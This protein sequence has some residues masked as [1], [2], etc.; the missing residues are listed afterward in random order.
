MVHITYI[1]VVMFATCYMEIKR[2]LICYMKTWKALLYSHECRAVFKAITALGSIVSIRFYVFHFIF[3]NKVIF[4]KYY[5]GWKS[6][7]NHC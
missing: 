4:I 3:N 7:K 1:K 2:F 5:I 6:S